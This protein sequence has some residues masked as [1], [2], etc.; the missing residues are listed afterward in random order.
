[1]ETGRRIHAIHDKNFLNWVKPDEETKSNEVPWACPPATDI[2]PSGN[3]TAKT[4]M[5][6]S[7]I[8]RRIWLNLGIKACFSQSTS[9]SE[10][11]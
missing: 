11:T 5:Y 9:I 8:D 6:R 10:I 2:T 7:Y 1:M 3:V 4:V